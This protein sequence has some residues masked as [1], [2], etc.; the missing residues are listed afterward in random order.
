MYRDRVGLVIGGVG[1]GTG[2]RRAVGAG[3]SW[4]TEPVVATTAGLRR[5][6]F[7]VVGGEERRC[8]VV[9]EGRRSEYE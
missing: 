8:R 5:M 7:A 3:G 1:R 4:R 2:G 6:A 9:E